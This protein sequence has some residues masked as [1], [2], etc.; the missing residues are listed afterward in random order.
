[1]SRVEFEERL[2][3]PEERLPAREDEET[4][5]SFP[6]EGF[7][8]VE[9]TASGSIRGLSRAGAFLH[10]ESPCDRYGDP[11]DPEA[12]RAE[13]HARAALTLD[14]AGAACRRFLRTRLR[15]GER[16]RF[17]LARAELVIRDGIA[18]Y[19]LR[20]AE[21]PG[22][23]V[24]AVYP[25]L[26][27]FGMDPAS[28]SILYVFSKDLRATL[29]GAPATSRE[30]AAT[31]ARR[32]ILRELAKAPAGVELV[33]VG[34]P[35]L[36]PAPAPRARDGEGIPRYLVPFRVRGPEGEAAAVALIDGTTGAFLEI[37]R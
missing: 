27:A 21:V 18:T 10:L 33:E 25:N 7:G 17:E 34:E 35:R 3:E 12:A 32:Y 1:M 28:G 16:R 24:F 8:R 4:V 15:D 36:V 26:F 22:K 31:L 9:V 14:G 30:R 5:W 23:D 19:E 37:R 2:G 11:E 13:V 29:A 6:I 20:F